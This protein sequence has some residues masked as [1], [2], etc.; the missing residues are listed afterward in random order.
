MDADIRPGESKA[1]DFNGFFAAHTAIE[2]VGFN[3]QTAAK[4]FRQLVEPQL[5]DRI[6]TTT[7]PSTSPA[8]A[9]MPY[10]EKLARWRD[11]MTTD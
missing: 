5:E 6:S 4:L 2:R 7:L 10:A 11:F 8:Y 9:A 3:G 1:N